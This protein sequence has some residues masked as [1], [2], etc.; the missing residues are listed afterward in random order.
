MQTLTKDISPAELTGLI[1]VVQLARELQSSAEF[2]DQTLHDCIFEAAC[3]IDHA[4]DALKIV[5]EPTEQ[6]EDDAANN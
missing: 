5:S 1:R 3:L 6:D 4:R 2:K